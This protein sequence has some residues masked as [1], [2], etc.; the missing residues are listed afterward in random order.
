MTTNK[1]RAVSSR[2]ACSMANLVSKKGC[3]GAVLRTIV[4][5]TQYDGWFVQYAFAMRAV[6]LPWR[7]GYQM[8]AH[9]C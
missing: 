5:K 9:G 6:V 2:L 3:S 1:L 7:L 8:T 4:L